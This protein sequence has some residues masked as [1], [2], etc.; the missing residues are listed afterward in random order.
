MVAASGQIGQRQQFE[1]LLLIDDVR[2]HRGAL[3]VARAVHAFP[4]RALSVEQEDEVEREICLCFVVVP[5]G[6][7]HV[8]TDSLRRPRAGVDGRFEQ[9][10]QLV[11]QET[12]EKRHH[13]RV[14]RRF[15][16]VPD[17]LQHQDARPQIRAGR[18]E[19]AVL[20]LAG[21]RPVDPFLRL[22][23]QVGIVERVS[24][25]DQTAH[26]V[27]AAFPRVAR[28]AGPRVVLQAGRKLFQ[29][30]GV[31]VLLQEELGLEI[32][33]CR[34][35]AHGQ[36]RERR[37]VQAV[38]LQRR[39]VGRAGGRRRSRADE[40]RGRC[41]DAE[42]FLC[43]S[44]DVILSFRAEISLPYFRAAAY[45][46]FRLKL[47]LFL[48]VFHG[49]GSTGRKDHGIV[50]EKGDRKGG[51]AAAAAGNMRAIKLSLDPMPVHRLSY[52]R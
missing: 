49:R 43:R 35:A 38:R 23:L 25:R 18:A 52:H 27:G 13:A 6:D 45:P 7:V 34:D 19:G 11:A 12:V 1:A 44:H 5:Q 30:A 3:E 48:G 17:G 9:R 46:F 4:V 2:D 16:V 26:V 41:E 40:Q 50:K 31:A 22:R 20:P 15:A 51:A 47:S 14:A 33:L 8:I 32:A 29:M 37:V 24:R 39:P 21:Q 28:S 42:L 36:R 10:F